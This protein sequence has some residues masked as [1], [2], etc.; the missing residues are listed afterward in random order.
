MFDDYYWHYDYARLAWDTGFCFD[1]Y[2]Y[3]NLD[4]NKICLIDID[5]IIKERDVA[6]VERNLSIVVQFVLDN[7]Q[8]E[9]LDSNFVKLFRLAQL[10]VE[11]LL[12]CKKYL[13]KTVVLL[14]K[15]IIKMKE[16]LEE[17]KNYTEE[18]VS[19]LSPSRNLMTRFTCEM[20]LKMFSTEDY[21]NS[22]IKRRHSTNDMSI[23]INL[24]AD[25]L[26]S[27]IKELKERLN[28]TEKFIQ[29]KPINEGRDD[30]TT[31]L[32]SEIQE[33][34]DRFRKQVEEKMTSLQLEKNFFT[35]KYD[36]LFEI[37]LQYK[38]VEREQRGMHI[39][40]EKKRNVEN[41]STQTDKVRKHLQ[42]HTI[43]DDN[44][45]Y[46]EDKNLRPQEDIEEKIEKK[47]NDFEENIESKIS[48]G[49]SNIESQIQTF[50]QKISTPRL[51]EVVQT[52]ILDVEED[53][54]KIKPRSKL[55]SI[56]PMKNIENESILEKEVIES[57]YFPQQ[58]PVVTFVRGK[59][60]GDNGSDSDTKETIDSGKKQSDI[61]IYSPI[62]KKGNRKQSESISSECNISKI[63]SKKQKKSHTNDIKDVNLLE[64]ELNEKISATINNA[65]QEMGINPTWNG[66][67][68][69][70]FEKSLE[71]VKHQ[72]NLN[73]KSFPRYDSLKK[74]I[75]KLV[76][77]TSEKKLPKDD[78]K[79]TKT[80]KIQIKKNEQPKSKSKAIIQIKDPSFYDS[81]SE[82]D[83]DPY[84]PKQ[85]KIE[86]NLEQKQAH[87]AVIEELQAKFSKTMTNSDT[88]PVIES[89]EDEEKKERKSSMKNVAA[90]GSLVRKKVFFEM[91]E[92][93]ISEKCDE[94]VDSLSDFE[95]T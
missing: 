95:L 40:E 39:T 15:D 14:K 71:I 88:N 7:D 69:R 19:H 38:M 83:L 74:S 35:D 50:W 84:L 25:K 51:T 92:S 27:E 16:Q 30:K 78:T 37:V 52:E 13:D 53:K 85:F 2:K 18:L 45:F 80:L 4:K 11:Y 59:C 56:S 64:T 34:F 67:P 81:D 3:P 77:T 89:V 73:K 93:E 17:T 22:H 82:A 32:V 28:N 55:I 76:R 46:F 57:D 62:I 66:I 65:L 91:Q 33:S 12:F 23:P 90:E 43:R 54:P 42:I 31:K 58:E 68:K 36:K 61:V 29:E 1:K 10:S 70:T 5:R 79:Y 87:D 41:I 26:H 44:T 9:V 63:S 60:S 49:L 6:S 20:C 75:E 48:T 47:F 86:E 8:A 94:K 72:E 21:L 24:E